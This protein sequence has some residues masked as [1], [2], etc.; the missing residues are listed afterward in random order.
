MNAKIGLVTVLYKSDN[1]LEDF[2]QSVSN[3]TF[4]NFILICID[5]S[6]TAHTKNLIQS[7]TE[8]YNLK[9]RVIHLVN[10]ENV[11]VAKGNN[12]GI[13]IA[14]ANECDFI[15]LL[16]NDIIFYQQHLFEELI[17][18]AIN[19][20]ESIIIP[21]IFFSEEQSNVIWM[22]GGNLD[23]LRGLVTHVGEGKVDNAIYNTPQYFNYAP[24]CF[25]LISKNVFTSIGG[26]DENYFVYYDDVDFIYRA[27]KKGF[28][29]YYLPTLSIYH[30]VGNSV[31]GFSSTY[32]YYFN[33]NR[34]YFSF[35]QL[36]FIYKFTSLFFYFITRLKW[37]INFKGEKRK[38]NFKGI[39]DGIKLCFKKPK[40]KILINDVYY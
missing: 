23:K 18:T 26:M 4:S 7:F 25:M 30:K 38:M 22:A 36:P 12:Q 16:N 13:E 31:G 24:T 15:I 37:Q 40:N 8:K 5:N 2:F 33:R 27:F 20:N 17:N 9:D 19:K 39:I 32:I 1:V 34:I 35:K 3:Q 14:F 11:G 10:I 28:H 6:P 21:K 29:V